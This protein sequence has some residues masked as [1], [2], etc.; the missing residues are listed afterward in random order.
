MIPAFTATHPKFFLPNAKASR[1][2]FLLGAA[3]I[4]TSL[5]VGYRA[6]ALAED[7]PAAAPA[8]PIN[9]LASYIKIDAD[10]KVTIYSSQ[11]EMGQGAYFGIATLVNEELDANW[12]SITVEGGSGNVALFGNVA[13]GGFA[14]GTGGSTSM[15]SSWERYRKAGAAARIMLQQAAAAAWN[16][17]AA[18]IKAEKG[19]LTHTSGKSDT[20]GEM[21]ASAGQIAIP[22]DVP[23]KPKDQWTQ[24]GA[25]DLKRY[26]SKFKTNGS[27]AYT[28][29][30]KLPDMKTAVMIHPPMFGATVKSFDAVKAKAIKGVVDVVQIPR[31]V[32][33]VADHMWAAI[34]GREAVTVE[35]DDTKAEKRGSAEIIADFRAQAAKPGIVT[36]RNDGSTDEAFK[37]AAKV[38]E[39]T[40]EFPYLAHAAMEPLNAVATK[41][42]DM[43]EIWGGHQM[44]DLYQYIASQ[45]A[46]T[47]PDK[48]K[49][50]VM[51]SGGGFGR[52]AVT[53]ADV[54]AEAV[55]IGQA[56]QWKYPVKVQWTRDNDMKGGR[57]RPAYVHWVKAGLDKEG[58]LVAWQNHIVGQSILKGTPFEQGLVT[59]G[60]DLTSVEG[61]SNIPYA[62]PNLKVDLSTMDTGVPVLWWRAVGST[63]TAFAVETF[64]DELAEAAGKDPVEFRLAMLEKSPRHASVLKLA[65]EK[66]GWS[67]PAAEGRFRGIALAESFSTVVAQVVEISMPKDG[68]MKVE[69]V[70]TAVDCGTVINPDQVKAQVEGAVGFGLGAILQ[71]ELSL[72]GGK[73]DQAN[74]DTYTPLRIN[75]M[76]VVEVHMLPSDA[77]PT[78]IGEPGV[79][80]VGPALANAVYQ[81][82]KKR[83]RVLPFA[84]GLSA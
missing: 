33:V 26:D 48:I 56:T 76:P 47:T 43:I 71:E 8:A 39:A 42:G 80:P 58:K 24:I 82:Q 51:K 34:K 30:A 52:R 14:Q 84:K 32:A 62:V 77:A 13:W 61:A 2:G 54:I 18:E 65:A 41:T 73:V 6:P 11:F 67:Q 28:I 40:F 66:A 55:A 17:P 19:M 69:R 20:Y 21:A 16:V 38:M 75:Q 1:R 23:L 31:G 15:A 5:V 44:P 59:N 22:A 27:Q 70:V 36:A 49:L 68:D 3:A 10:N 63:H 4:G 7:A 57:Y 53:D 83:V 45:V 79:P 35:W 81:A 64:I 46:G 25:A 60:V 74:Y 72:T 29:D 78:G 9:P 12:A 37:S 50:H